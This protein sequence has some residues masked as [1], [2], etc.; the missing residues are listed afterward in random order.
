M[1]GYDV[2]DG[3]GI[4]PKGTTKIEEFG[5][6]YRSNLNRV[7]IPP[8][9]TTIGRYAF[10]RCTNLESILTLEEASMAGSVKAS[11]FLAFGFMR[12]GAVFLATE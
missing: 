5:F 6:W 9:V 2:I 11:A 12:G 4:I 7:V 10:A 3:E 1:G 8:T